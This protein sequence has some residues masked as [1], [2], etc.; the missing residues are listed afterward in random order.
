MCME[1]LKFAG[2]IRNQRQNVG[3][4][5]WARRYK[6]NEIMR[7]HSNH[8]NKDKHILEQFEGTNP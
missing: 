4:L 7:N 6:Q 3:K 1:T 8:L 5:E 2:K